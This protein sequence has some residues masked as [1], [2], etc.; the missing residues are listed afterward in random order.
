MKKAKLRVSE[1]AEFQEEVCAECLNDDGE[2][3]RCFIIGKLSSGGECDGVF[4]MPSLDKET[5]S[6]QK[7]LMRRTEEEVSVPNIIKWID[8]ASTE[9]VGSVLVSIEETYHYDVIKGL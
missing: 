4:D 3:K 5:G 7:C 1:L 6:F 9:E 8:T 2:D